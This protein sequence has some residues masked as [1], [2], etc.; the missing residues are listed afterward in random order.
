MRQGDPETRD[1]RGYNWGFY[2]EDNN[3]GAGSFWW[4]KSSEKLSRFIV[5]T[6]T[7]QYAQCSENEEIIIKKMQTIIRDADLSKGLTANLLRKVNNILET[8]DNNR[9]PTIHWCG[10]FSDLCSG[11]SAWSQNFVANFF[12]DCTLNNQETKPNKVTGKQ[13]PKFIQ[14]CQDYGH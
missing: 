7:P 13:I 12:E 14:Y 3:D 10:T 11:K 8:T 1:P 4:F 9:G 5:D 2:I 6:V